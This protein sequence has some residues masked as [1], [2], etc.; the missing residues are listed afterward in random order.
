M[1]QKTIK[2]QKETNNNKAAYLEANLEVITELR[3]ATQLTVQTL[4]DEAV[5]FIRAV[6][7][8]VIVV[9]QQS[10]IQTLPIAACES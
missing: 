10:L 6:P 2:K 1:G 5:E 3:A 8:V 9:A 4:V 7:T